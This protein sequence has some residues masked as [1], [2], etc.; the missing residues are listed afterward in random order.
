MSPYDKLL[1]EQYISIHF[2]VHHLATEIVLWTLEEN[3]LLHT[4]QPSSARANH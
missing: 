3:N 4:T 2:C 1:I